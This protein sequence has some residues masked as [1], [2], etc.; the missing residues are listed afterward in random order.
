VSCDM[1][2]LGQ[3]SR[4]SRHGRD[5]EEQGQD[6]LQTGYYCVPSVSW[7]LCTRQIPE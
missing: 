1:H 2:G 4:D 3:V 7:S 5:G 6:H